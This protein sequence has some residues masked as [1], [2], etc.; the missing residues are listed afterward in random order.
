MSILFALAAAATPMPLD[1]D[2]VLSRCAA[3]AV[4]LRHPGR[5]MDTTGVKFGWLRA[6][7]KSTEWVIIG[8][9]VE[10]EQHSRVERHLVCRA[11]GDQTPRVT[12]GK[13]V[14]S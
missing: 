1:R 14:R 9:I 12:F 2:A 3:R 5:D 6:T 4:V 13:V 7:A 8:S 11:R 10:I